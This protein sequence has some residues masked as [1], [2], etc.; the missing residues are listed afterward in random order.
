MPIY[1]YQGQQYDIATDD[2][3]AAKNKILNYINSQ[4]QQ[5]PVTPAP[6]VQEGPKQVDENAPDFSRGLGNELGSLQNV[7]G[8]AKVLAGKA[9]GSESLMQSGL[10][11]MKAGEAKTEVKPTDELSEA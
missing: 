4:K 7:W 9:L 1:E 3:A 10:E 5:A 8:G 2:H 6:A 11:S